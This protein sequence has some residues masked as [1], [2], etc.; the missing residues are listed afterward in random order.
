MRSGLFI[1]IAFVFI[2][3]GAL[4][5]EPGA[6]KIMEVQTELREIRMQ[7]DELI[8]NEAALRDRQTT[9]MMR[10]EEDIETIR[11][12][13]VRQISEAGD[14]FT[15]EQALIMEYIEI[16][17]TSIRSMD[18]KLDEHDATLESLGSKVTNAEQDLEGIRALY[19]QTQEKIHAADNRVSSMGEKVAA[20]DAALSGIEA[21]IDEKAFAVNEID[22]IKQLI[23]D[24]TRDVS[25]I[26]S[27][28]N[29]LSAGLEKKLEEQ[30]INMQKLEKNIREEVSEISKKIAYTDQGVIEKISTAE[31]RISYLNE[32]IKEREIYL[33]GAI[34]GI[35]FLMLMVAFLA[36]SSRRKA[37]KVDRKLEQRDSELNHR[38]EEQGAILDTRLV[39]MLEKQIPLL[40]GA[41]ASPGHPATSGIKPADDHTLAIVLGEEIYRLMKRNKKLSEQSPVSEELK[42]SLR[43]LWTTF[44]EKGY[45]IVDL[46]DKKYNEDME[47]KADF[48][49]THELLPGEQIV[50]RVIKPLIKRNN[51]TIQKAEIEVMVG[52]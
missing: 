3:T 42:A 40:S 11:Q 48:F 13:L 51:V 17:N 45:E 23:S 8:K 19:E 2:S 5:Q 49:L 22:A 16:I 27:D 25:E 29:Q 6:T 28:F 12:D 9:R 31:S 30:I 1:I 4:A 18:I 41:D 50:S 46:Q 35:G 20:I 47:A 37:V 39:E 26:E 10:L 7:M 21:R 36:L 44:R 33:A 15:R 38:I 14:A 24:T 34:A 32:Y 52:E 43:R